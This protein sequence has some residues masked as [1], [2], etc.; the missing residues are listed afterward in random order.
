MHRIGPCSTYALRSKITAKQTLH[1]LAKVTLTSPISKKATESL[2]EN[3][4][5]QNTTIFTAT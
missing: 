4:L 1:D 3:E 5:E 2:Q